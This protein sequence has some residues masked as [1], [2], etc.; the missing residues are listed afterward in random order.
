MRMEMPLPALLEGA[1]PSALLVYFAIFAADSAFEKLE[2]LRDRETRAAQLEGE[3]FR[4]RL[5]ALSARLQP[6]FLFNTLHTIAGLV[7]TVQPQAALCTIADLS[8]LLRSTLDRTSPETALSDE[9][10]MIERYLAIQKTRL[11]DRLRVEI[12]VEEETRG[13]L[14]PVLLLQPI[15]E[16]A[17]VHGIERCPGPG[18]VAIRARRRGARLDL[19][20]IDSGPGPND[21]SAR[22]GIGLSVTRARLAHLFGEDFDLRLDRGPEGGA[23][24][25]ISIPWRGNG[26]EDRES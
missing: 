7:R 3:L 15:V 5:D 25:R 14:V 8:D 26:T 13:A 2:R 23:V 20:V 11:S 17:L 9:L 12:D 21:E 1:L 24:A 6:H 18:R 4:A 10:A 16:N 19:S 22:D